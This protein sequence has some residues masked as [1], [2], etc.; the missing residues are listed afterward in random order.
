MMTK[1]STPQANQQVKIIL[2][3]SSA[4]KKGMEDEEQSNLFKEWISLP[5]TSSIPS[6]SASDIVI[7]NLSQFECDSRSPIIF[8]F[9]HS[10]SQVYKPTRSS[11]RD[12]EG[13]NVSERGEKAYKG[14]TKKPINGK[15]T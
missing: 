12:N 14:K 2:H 9:L 3:D 6:S 7:I 1:R 5:F 4:A 13:H 10:A 8:L 15:M 11:S